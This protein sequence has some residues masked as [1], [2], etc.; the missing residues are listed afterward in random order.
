[1]E[2][3]KSKQGG[4]GAIFLCINQNQQHF[5]ENIKVGVVPG[6]GNHPRM[7]VMTPHKSTTPPLIRKVVEVTTNLAPSRAIAIGADKL[8]LT[9]ALIRLSFH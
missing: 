4:D 7:C 8:P 2:V 3:H 6:I 9:L 1:M 5:Y